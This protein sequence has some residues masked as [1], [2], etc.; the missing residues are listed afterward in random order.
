MPDELLM[1]T[2]AIQRAIHVVILCTEFT[3]NSFS[4]L[5]INDFKMDE[6]QLNEVFIEFPILPIAEEITLENKG[7]Q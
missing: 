6:L 1:L 5:L 4:K 3:A 7:V 2:V